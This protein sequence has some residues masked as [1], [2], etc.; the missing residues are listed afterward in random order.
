MNPSR[1]PSAAKA[2]TGSP[3][4][5]AAYWG[6]YFASSGGDTS[7]GSTPGLG[8]HQHPQRLQQLGNREHRPDLVQDD[9]RLARPQQVQVEVGFGGV[10]GH[11]DVPAAGIEAGD[12][13]QG[14]APRR[15]DVGEVAVQRRAP[16]VLDQADGDLGPV[17]AVPAEPDQGVAGVAVLAED[18]GHLVAGLGAQA[19]DPPEAPGGQVVEPREGEV[20]QVEQQQAAA[21][22]PG[23]Q[24]A[25]GELLVRRGSGR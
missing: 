2:A 15:E 10:D 9:R 23:D 16:A 25:A 24:L 18:V 17:G 20:A 14:Q 22:Q 1:R 7:N 11:L 6:R 21:G 3:W 13:G 4:P 5:R 12:L 8:R 19:A